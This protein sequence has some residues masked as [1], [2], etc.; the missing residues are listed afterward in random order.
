[1]NDKGIGAFSV[2]Q[3]FSEFTSRGV[4]LRNRVIVSPM[5]MYSAVEGVPNDWHLVH[6]GSRAVGGAG[7]VLTEAA[8]ISPE[9][10][11]SPSDAGI[12]NEDQRAAWAKIAAFIERQ[13][14]APGVQLA[15]AGRKASMLPPWFAGG[16]AEVT[17]GGWEPMGPTAD[18]FQATYWTPREMNVTDI[19]RIVDDFA[20]AA[21]RAM[22]AGFRIVEIHAAHGYLLHQFLSPLVNTRTDAYGGGLDQ[23]LRLPLAVC[24]AVREALPKEWPV[25]LR[26]SATDWHAGGWDVE[27][28][29]EFARRAAAIGIDMV[30]CSSGGAVSGVQIPTRPGYQVPFAAR[31][32]KEAPVPTYA[33]G[34]ITEPAQAEAII[35]AGEADA[36]ALA[37]GMLRDPY[38]PRHAASAL[39]VPLEWPDQYKRA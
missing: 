29:I 24:Q 10:R 19:R 35:A 15:H 3:L 37:R 32:R 33:V 16:R 13:G 7:A 9:G 23:R 20:D 14:S 8:A 30:G 1:M 36:V 28:T 31:L 6:L 22:L 5:C 26:V 12:W 25:W 39:G 34:L 21:R 18:A 38:W 27:Q 4:T 17:D 2:S 11:I